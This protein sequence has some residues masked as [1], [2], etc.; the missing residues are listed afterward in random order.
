MFGYVWRPLQSS[1]MTN[2]VISGALCYEVGNTI[3]ID[4]K[5]KLSSL[6]FDFICK[7]SLIINEV[8]FSGGKIVQVRIA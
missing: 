2:I 7:E 4:L 6:I 8:D 5:L 1:L 3:L